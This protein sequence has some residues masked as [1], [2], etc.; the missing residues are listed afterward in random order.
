MLA[1]NPVTEEE[2]Y[3]DFYFIPKYWDKQTKNGNE[4]IVERL[5]MIKEKSRDDTNILFDEKNEKYGYALYAARGDVVIINEELK[6]GLTA[7]YGA[8]A[9]AACDLT[10]VTQKFILFFIALLEG[11]Y[12]FTLCK[13]GLDP[14]KAGEV[15]S[16]VN[17]NIRSQDELPPAVKFIMENSKHSYPI[18]ESTKD[19]RAR[20]L[21]YCNNK[22]TELHFAN[23]QS[24][25][26][27]DGTFSL[28]N[29]QRARKDGVIAHLAARSA[30]NVF[31]HNSKTGAVNK[32][33]LFDFRAQR[34]AQAA[35]KAQE[36]AK[37]AEI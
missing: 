31:I 23:A 6:V 4:I 5:D 29:S 21:V 28:I 12:R 17:T 30:Y 24:K 37:N 34:A 1:V 27:G 10:G 14:N 22:L 26:R 8:D 13:F 3:K 19:V 15:E 25:E 9:A 2:F 11:R 35:A 18:M 32:K 16:F 7:L 20:G 36:A 33:R